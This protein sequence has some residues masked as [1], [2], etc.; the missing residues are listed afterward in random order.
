MR[1]RPRP[2]ARCA[3]G[4][5]KERSA[6]RRSR[7]SPAWAQRQPAADPL[8]GP[9]LT[10]PGQGLKP[11]ELVDKPLEE[12]SKKKY[13]LARDRIKARADGT[14]TSTASGKS[15]K[16]YGS[17]S[18]AKT[19][20]ILPQVTASF[21]LGNYE[22]RNGQEAAAQAAY[23]QG[24][25]KLVQSWASDPKQA[26][27]TLPA[28]SK[29]IKDMAA[30][31]NNDPALL[32]ALM[33]GLSDSHKQ[34]LESIKDPRTRRSYATPLAGA[35]SMLMGVGPLEAD[36]A[37]VGTF[38]ALQVPEAVMINRR[39]NPTEQQEM[40]AALAQAAIGAVQTAQAPGQ[41]QQ[42]GLLDRLMGAQTG[43]QTVQ[44]GAQAGSA[45]FMEA[46][47]AV[48]YGQYADSLVA[49]KKGWEELFE[50]AKADPQSVGPAPVQ[51][52]LGAIEQ[53]LRSNPA[54]AIILM[55]QLDPMHR[56]A[57]SSMPPIIPRIADMWMRL[58]GIAQELPGAHLANA[59]FWGEAASRDAG[60]KN[61]H[62]AQLE[63]L[64]QQVETLKAASASARDDDDEDDDDGKEDDDKPGARGRE[65][66]DKDGQK[67]RPAP[68]TKKP[69]PGEL[70]HEPGKR[71]DPKDMIP[72]SR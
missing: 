42:G 70:R 17:E 66:E 58:A 55:T 15:S 56:T 45:R 52:E 23:Q 65:R 19:P 59:V 8:P 61:Q 7:G 50:Q 68:R 25:A 51:V 31:A 64:K 54:A 36:S 33:K 72:R 12:K 13:E 16:G 60:F 4:R 44:I 57:G 38:W 35:W 48:R 27:R 6:A 18:T 3:R 43:G 9:G 11:R 69:P 29:H 32:L 2:V 63:S 53:A 67:A 71:P 5:A 30:L 14:N 1:R 62:Q 41:R 22:L 40:Q 34:G 20:S 28:S 21:E 37:K 39:L 26:P 47:V 10:L 24:W 46:G 49:F